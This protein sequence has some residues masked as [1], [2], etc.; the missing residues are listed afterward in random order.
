MDLCRSLPHQ[1]DHGS[2]RRFRL[3]AHAEARSFG[4]RFESDSYTTLKLCYTT[5]IESFGRRRQFSPRGQQSAPRVVIPPFDRSFRRADCA[6]PDCVAAGALWKWGKP[7]HRSWQFQQS[8]RNRFSPQNFA[9]LCGRARIRRKSAGRCRTGR[10]AFRRCHGCRVGGRN[11]GRL[12]IGTHRDSRSA[13]SARCI[14]CEASLID[15]FGQRRQFN[16][17]GR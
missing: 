9:R 1:I 14:W 13:S 5:L 7:P 8:Q 15:S 11:S 4:L 12:A 17:R 10:G 3:A 16:P 2:L 6:A